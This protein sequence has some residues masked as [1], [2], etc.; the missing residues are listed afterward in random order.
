MLEFEAEENFTIFEDCHD[1]IRHFFPCWYRWSCNSV[2]SFVIF[3]FLG[4][5]PLVFPKTMSY[6]FY[7]QEERLRR[8][9]R[10][11]KVYFDASKLDH[12][13]YIFYNFWFSHVFSYFTLHQSKHILLMIWCNSFKD[14]MLWE[15][16][17]LLPSLVMSSK[18]WF[19][20]NGK[21]WDGREEIHLLI[22]GYI[23]VSQSL[24]DVLRLFLFLTLFLL[25]LQ[26]W[27]NFLNRGAGFISLENLLFFAKTFSVSILTSHNLFKMD[28]LLLAL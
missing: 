20:I 24:S 19:L 26:F 18:A 10:R 22:S 23:F 1:Q 17:G 14:R 5:G 11:M 9:K 7:L 21:K 4:Y 13:V 2:C 15:L 25:T 8:L 3:S 28:P 6:I 12:Q 16:F 27:T